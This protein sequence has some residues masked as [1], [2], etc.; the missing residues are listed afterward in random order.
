MERV[1]V[2]GPV[3]RLFH[4]SLVLTFGANALVIDDDSAL[5]EWVGYTVMGL[6]LLRILWGFV[7]PGYARFASFPPS[8]SGAV[9]QL[10]DIATGRKRV[11]LG[12]TPLGALMIYNLLAA[13]LAIGLSGHLMTTDMFWGQEWPE[14]LHE[15]AVAWAEVSVVL[16]IAAVLYESHRTGV[17]LPR[18][19]V[20]GYKEI[21]PR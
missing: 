12:H 7:G 21:P 20:R 17:N 8:L 18:A 9:G 13:L 3:V 11:H 19:M 10:T 1:K 15:V 5:H 16:H 2:W 6:V 4:W 14:E